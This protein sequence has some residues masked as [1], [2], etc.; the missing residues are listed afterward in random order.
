MQAAGID[1]FVEVG[2]GHTLTGLVKRTLEGVTT[3]NVENPDQ[4]EDVVR[5]LEEA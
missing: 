2:P 4:L 3:Y 1:T 5:A